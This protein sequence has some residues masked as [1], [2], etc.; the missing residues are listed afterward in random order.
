[1]LTFILSVLKEILL[2]I[3]YGGGIVVMIISIF[4][5]P[6]WGLFLIVALRPQPNIYYKFYSFPMGQHFLDLAFLAVL[7]GMVVNKRGLVKNVNSIVITIFIVIS[8]LALVNCSMRFNLPFPVTIENPLLADWKNYAEMIAMYFLALNAI[9]SERDQKSVVIIMCLAVLFISI[10][11]YR[12]Y[13][14]GGAFSEDSRYGGPFETVH[15]NPNHFAAFIAEYSSVFLGL[16]LLDK[17]R[18]RKWLY[19]AT[20]LFSLHP[21]FFSYSRGAYIAAFGV[22]VFFGLIRKRSLLILVFCLYLGWQAILPAS[23]VDRISMTASQNGELENSAAMRLEIW[24]YAIDLYKQNRIFGVGFGGY[25]LSVLEKTGH[26]RDSHNIYLKTLSEQGIVGLVLLLLVFCMAFYS[27]WKLFKMGKTPFQQ[28]L[29]LGFLGCIVA[30]MITNMFGD[31]W[32]YDVL[33]TYFWV[34]WAMVDRGILITETAKQNAGLIENTV[35]AE[36][37][38]YQVAE[39]GRNA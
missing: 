36:G 23:V 2:P 25:A 13:T 29:G 26:P 10:R 11:T 7:V 31:R 17:N 32:S 24:N 39:G 38:V 30:L 8:Y 4:W 33:G 14:A 3:I 37:S 5:R 12:D 16:F 27:G 35:P 6:E 21:L 28:G 19:L 1:M 18:V 22:L 34:F 15:L 9:E 20:V